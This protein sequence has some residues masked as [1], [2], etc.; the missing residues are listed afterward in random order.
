M[1]VAEFKEVKMSCEPKTRFAT[2]AGI[3][4]LYFGD[5]IKLYLK[6]LPLADVDT[7]RADLWSQTSPAGLLASAAPTTGPLDGV[8]AAFSAVPNKPYDWYCTLDLLTGEIETALTSQ[9]PG[10]P[11]PVHLIVGDTNGV[12]VD[13]GMN[14]YHNPA[15][16]AET[17]PPLAGDP[18]VSGSALATALEPYALIDDTVDRSDLYAD[19]LVVQA[20]P[21]LNPAQ[22]EA[23]FNALL[24]LL[25]SVSTPA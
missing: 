20:M 13:A 25:V 8:V 16:S 15:L 1:S 11:Y 2:V 3:K 24:A 12:W 5:S 18:F 9:T 6:N 4:D 17:I 7:L 14:L 10:E 22:S 21:T 23:R 19:L